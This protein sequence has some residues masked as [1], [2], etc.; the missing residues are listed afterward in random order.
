[1]KQPTD[2][3]ERNEDKKNPQENPSRGI[4]PETKEPEMEATQ[5]EQK[6]DAAWKKLVNE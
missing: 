1:M 2:Q 5:K 4:D 6:K 3:Q